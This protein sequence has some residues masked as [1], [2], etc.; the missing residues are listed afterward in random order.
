MNE[1]KINAIPTAI[2]LHKLSRVLE[3]EFDTGERFFLPCAYLRAYSPSAEMRHGA[4]LEKTEIVKNQVNI[5]AI[6][7]VGQYAIRPV[8]SDGHRTGIYSWSTL[9]ELGKN[10]ADNWTN[11]ETGKK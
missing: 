11:I 2:T 5:L 8:F 10:L 7:P 9:H 1:E 3:V 6:E 4:S